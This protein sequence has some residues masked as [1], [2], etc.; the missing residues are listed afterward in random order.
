M[1]KKLIVATLCL[2]FISYIG[3]A[4]VESTEIGIKVGLNVADIIGDETDGFDVRSSVHLGF[5]VEVPIIEELAIQPELFYS[6]QGI[7]TKSEEPNFEDEILK[8]DYIQLPLM[9]KY[10][11][12][13]VA[14]GFSLEV[15]PQVGF[16][17]SAV[18][19]RKN[20]TNGGVEKSDIN[21][22]EIISDIDYG[23]NFGLGYQFEMGAFFQARYSLG[24]A[25]VIDAEDSETWR[26]SVFQF[27]TGYKF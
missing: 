8:L 21:V 6:F 25:N 16:S 17:T 7:K 24:I 10:Y 22:D 13:Y 19:E 12:F 27:S 14:P 20:R 9:I 26:N 18:I 1:I 11:P 15:G 23:V 4:Q 2:G 5:V 3:K